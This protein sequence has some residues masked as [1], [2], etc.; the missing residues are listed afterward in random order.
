MLHILLGV[1]KWKIKYFIGY[2]YWKTHFKFISRNDNNTNSRLCEHVFAHQNCLNLIFIRVFSFFEGFPIFLIV[3]RDINLHFELQTHRLVT[4]SDQLIHFLEKSKYSW[5]KNIITFKY[6]KKLKNDIKKTPNVG[7]YYIY[8]VYYTI[9]M[10][11][12]RGPI[13]V[14]FS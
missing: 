8:N 9:F 1:F 4:I 11:V 3:M 10:Y 7:I 5:Q 13:A 6:I 14:D 2:L 12:K